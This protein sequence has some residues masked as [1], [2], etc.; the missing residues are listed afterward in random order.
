MDHLTEQKLAEIDRKIYVTTFLGSSISQK[1]CHALIKKGGYSV[2]QC[3]SRQC[4]GSIYCTKHNDDES[5]NLI[6]TLAFK[7]EYENEPEVY[8]II[9]TIYMY[10]HKILNAKKKTKKWE[11]KS[12][13]IEFLFNPYS[14][15]YWT[16][17]KPLYFLIGC[18][19]VDLKLGVELP[20]LEYIR[21]CPCSK[22]F[23]YSSNKA[24]EYCE[25]CRTCEDCSICMVKRK[26]IIPMK[27]C[28][29]RMCDHCWKTW[30]RKR[31]CPFCRQPMMKLL[32]HLLT[33]A[34]FVEKTPRQEIEIIDL[35]I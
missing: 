15:Y 4:S 3:Q 9:C 14:M 11:L 27:C 32:D 20:R 2:G 6:G 13:L 5:V 33:H 22:F 30:E 19:N 35:T 34:V 21:K 31:S 16:R 1:R 18:V 17:M 10:R 7:Q 8:G 28:N 29:N 26:H 24:Q 12:A 25:K 23:D